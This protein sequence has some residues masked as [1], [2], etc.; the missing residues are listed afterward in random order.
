MAKKTVKLLDVGPTVKHII[1]NKGM[2]REG[3]VMTVT[4][5]EDQKCKCLQINRQKL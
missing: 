5:D 3:N 1:T 2:I 4:S